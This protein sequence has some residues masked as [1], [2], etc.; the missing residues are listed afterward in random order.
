MSLSEKVAALPKK[1]PTF[2]ENKSG[3]KGYMGVANKKG[4]NK[5]E[6]QKIGPAVPGGSFIRLAAQPDGNCFFSSLLLLIRKLTIGFTEDGRIEFTKL[7][8]ETQTTPQRIADLRK[9]A[10]VFFKDVSSANM[11]AAQESII[12]D[13]FEGVEKDKNFTDMLMAM[14]IA[15]SIL[16]GYRTIFLNATNGDPRVPMIPR[17]QCMYNML[18]EQRIILFMFY[19]QHFEPVFF[20]KDGDSSLPGKGIF[21]KG[22]PEL[23]PI[24]EMLK[25]CKEQDEGE[26]A[27]LAAAMAASLEE[28]EQKNAAAMAASLEE[29]EKKNAA[30]MAGE[31]AVTLPEKAQKVE[32]IVS[33][34]VEANTKIWKAKSNTFLHKGDKHTTGERPLEERLKNPLIPMKGFKVK[35]CRGTNNDCII[36]SLL[37]CLSPTFRRLEGEFKDKV[38]SYYRYEHLLPM[39]RVF[40]KGQA[41]TPGG[42]KKAKS[43]EAEI[44]SGKDS[45]TADKAKVQKGGYGGRPISAEVAAA[46]GIIHGINVLIKESEAREQGAFSLL[47]PRPEAPS[48]IIIHNIDGVHYSSISDSI[49]NYTFPLAMIQPWIDE[50]ERKQH[51]VNKTKCPFITNQV[52]RHDGRLFIVVNA[53]NTDDDQGCK[54]VYIRE[55]DGGDVNEYKK[56]IQNILLIKKVLSPPTFSDPGKPGYNHDVEMARHVEWEGAK[57]GAQRALD[58]LKT[59]YPVFKKKYKAFAEVYGDAE[60]LPYLNILGKEGYELANPSVHDKD[61]VPS[62]YVEFVAAGGEEVESVIQAKA[63]GGSQRKSRFRKTRKKLSHPV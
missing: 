33:A 25:A 43:I 34:F 51:T 37:T 49:D 30:A 22:D 46:F 6:Y 54:H 53:E 56:D 27:E 1:D 24:F 26:N 20:L 8:R 7:F 4:E 62:T 18:D 35:E 10:E 44:R 12:E 32:E 16:P 42:A 14:L 5:I 59:R 55:L 39:Y 47:G 61:G 23:K 19:G 28:Q 15:E 58:T 13:A 36:N 57:A 11:A 60:K 9:N 41:L 2:I 45:Y 48:F 21:D 31:V 52:L 50:I 40:I 63:G 38:A 3:K 29:Q 17:E